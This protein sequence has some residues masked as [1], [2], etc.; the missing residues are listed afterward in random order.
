MLNLN[1]WSLS[2]SYC[3]ERYEPNEMQRRQEE[4]YSST[5]WEGLRAVAAAFAKHLGGARAS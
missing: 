1:D 4:L 3:G 2:L 5:S